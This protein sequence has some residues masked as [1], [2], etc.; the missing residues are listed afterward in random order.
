MMD[1]D[2]ARAKLADDLRP[3]DGRIQT[4]VTHR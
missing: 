1:A 3:V 2:M 4:A